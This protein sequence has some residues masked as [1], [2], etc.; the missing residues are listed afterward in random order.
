MVLLPPVDEGL[1]VAHRHLHPP[2]VQGQGRAR[3]VETV[4]S[5]DKVQR[6]EQEQTHGR[7]DLMFDLKKK[8]TFNSWHI[9]AE[10]PLAHLAMVPVV[11]ATWHSYAPESLSSTRWIWGHP[12]H[13]RPTQ[14]CSYAPLSGT[15]FPCLKQGIA[16][17]KYQYL[18]N[19][20]CNLIT[21]VPSGNT[22]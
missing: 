20:F 13:L 15:L 4:V 19:V 11:V 7:L 16:S 9:S 10:Y 6:G 22:I 14:H 21:A 3:T 2:G 5:M 18:G 12:V 1:G 8:M 17:S